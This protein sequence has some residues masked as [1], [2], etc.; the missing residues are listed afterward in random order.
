MKPVKFL[1]LILIFS[2]MVQCN[3]LS[4]FFDFVASVT[5][6]DCDSW[7]SYD[8]NGNLSDECRNLNNYLDNDS[9]DLTGDLN[10]GLAQIIP[11]RNIAFDNLTVIQVTNINGEPVQNLDEGNVTCEYSP[12]DEAYTEINIDEIEKLSEVD[13]LQASISMVVD[14]S[15]S[16][17]DRDLDDVNVGLETFYEGLIPEST[18]L[19]YQSSIIKFAT[20]VDMVQDFTSVKADLLDAVR[21]TNYLRG[22]TSLFDAIYEA[23]DEIKDEDTA[24]RL[25]VLFTDGRDNDS[26]YADKDS[27]IDYAK[28]HKVPVCVV[29]VSFADVNLLEEIAR[30]TGCFYIYKKTFASL[31]DAF[32]AFAD[33]INNFRVIDLE[34]D[35]VETEGTIKVKVETAEEETREFTKEM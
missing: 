14:Y 30:E 5:P 32:D 10:Q 33:Q 7:L 12:D 9:T 18:S 15:G 21:D 1:F 34:D 26:R 6:D 27:A 3:G 16:I 20:N 35:F 29:G 22:A 25:V 23:V 19:G 31:E 17:L 8:S 28:E 13:S 2:F 11:T 4:D 24:L